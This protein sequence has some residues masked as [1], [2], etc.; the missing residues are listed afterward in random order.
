MLTAASNRISISSSFDAGN[1]EVVDAEDP[2]N[3]QLKIRP[4]PHCAKDGRSHFQW[5]YFQVSG[6]LVHEDQGLQMC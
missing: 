2:A 3:I 4:D 5:F 6:V 1:I